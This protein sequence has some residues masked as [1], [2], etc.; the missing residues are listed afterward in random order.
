METFKKLDK[1]H[2]THLGL[3]VF[4]LVELAIAY[5]G[6]NKSLNTGNLLWY[7]VTIVTFYG[8]VSNLFRFIGSFIH[9]KHKASKA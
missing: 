1:W 4:G 9:G 8:G 3:L 7:I 5:A 2:K 6:Y